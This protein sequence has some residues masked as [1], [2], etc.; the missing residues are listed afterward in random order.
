MLERGAAVLQNVA[1]GMHDGS[2]DG[3]G[4]DALMLEAR[5]LEDD[6]YEAIKEDGAEAMDEDN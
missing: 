1:L 3:L 5:K 6:E 2:E 4:R